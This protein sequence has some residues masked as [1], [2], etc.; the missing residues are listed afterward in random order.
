VI[1]LM[2]EENDEE[3]LIERIA[4][5]LNISPYEAAARLFAF[6]DQLRSRRMFG[7]TNS[8]NNG[9]PKPGVGFLEVTRQCDTRCRLCYVNSGQALP[10]TLTGD[11]IF[12]A[13]DQMV[14]IGV[15]FI[16]L[17][18]GDPLTRDDLPDILTHICDHHGRKAGVSTSLLSLSKGLAKDFKRLGVLVQ[19]SLDG[20]TAEL[21]D[22]NRGQGAYEKAMKGIELLNEFE[23]PFRFAYVIYRH[24]VGD[25]E[26]MVNLGVELGAREIAFGKAKL[27]GRAATASEQ[28][29]PGVE[30]MIPVYHKLYRA[31][32]DT[33]STGTRIRCK[34]NQG[35]LSGL[36]DR[37][38][39]L[40]CGAGRT[41]VHVAYNGAI[42]P[43]SL[44][45]GSEDFLLGN[46]RKD[47]LEDV[48]E[49]SAV[50]RAFRDTTADDIAVCRECP[51]KYLCGGGCRADAYLQNSDFYAACGDCEDLLAYYPWLLVRGCKE[52]YVTAF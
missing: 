6:A 25:I 16:A 9:L 43:C 38:G 46:I 45:D 22:W 39:C 28:I 14:E 11:E 24:N 7:E 1:E 19:V 40:P 44:L 8:R 29:A 23:V 18:G 17:S 47:K 41:L 37:V 10:D 12:D 35:L 49:N 26:S 2:D 27:A 51:A 33:R 21:N 15:Q 5:F 13:I 48:W 36:D 52:E 4:E 34:Y 42:V 50:L 20:S 31:E 32:I 3:K 30:E